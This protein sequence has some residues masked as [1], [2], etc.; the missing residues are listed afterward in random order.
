[1][2]PSTKTCYHLPMVFHIKIPTRLLPNQTFEH[3]K[4]VELGKNRSAKE[5][6][7]VI[8]VAA[9]L[10]IKPAIFSPHESSLAQQIEEGVNLPGSMFSTRNFSPVKGEVRAINHQKERSL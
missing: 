8:N 5:T 2:Q 4:K 1:M 3:G 6:E 7:T 9:E 10:G